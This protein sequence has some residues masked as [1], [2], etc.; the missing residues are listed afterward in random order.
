MREPLGDSVVNHLMKPSESS[1]RWVSLQPGVESQIVCFMELRERGWLGKT[2]RGNGALVPP[3]APGLGV[4][5]SGWAKGK[6][7][8]GRRRPDP[9][10]G[11]QGGQRPPSPH[12][13]WS[14]RQRRLDAPSGPPSQVLFSSRCLEGRTSAC[15]VPA[16]R[17]PYLV[18]ISATAG[19][20]SGWRNRLSRSGQN[21]AFI[22]YSFL[23]KALPENGNS[24]FLT[25]SPLNAYTCGM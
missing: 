24:W 17:G 23:L 14:P 13:C 9:E 21:G 25:S 16:H 5:S 11:L 20:G 2:K 12:L 22:P 1:P 10:P 15:K 19:A 6:N 4:G 7:R 8:W 18:L 3:Q